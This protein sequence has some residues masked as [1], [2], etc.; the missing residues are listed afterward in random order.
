[1]TTCDWFFSKQSFACSTLFSNDKNHR[2]LFAEATK[3]SWLFSPFSKHP[4]SCA[5][6]LPRFNFCIDA[7]RNS[8][9]TSFFFLSFSS[10]IDHERGK[11]GIGVT[12]RVAD[13]RIKKID[14]KWQKNKTNFLLVLPLW[15]KNT[16]YDGKTSEKYFT[17]KK[18]Y[19][20]GF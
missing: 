16:A 3:A 9:E 17:H 2:I 7:D 10:S 5:S 4:F 19:K 15:K 1:M 11:G 6:K 18:I 14:D 13:E 8:Q 12:S 20:G